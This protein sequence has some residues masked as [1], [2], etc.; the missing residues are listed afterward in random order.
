VIDHVQPPEPRLVSGTVL[1]SFV[2]GFAI[3]T[4]QQIDIYDDVGTLRFSHVAEAVPHFAM[5]DGAGGLFVVSDHGLDF[6]DVILER[7]VL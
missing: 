2:G 5:P 7:L 3:Q 6:G 1:T 4:E